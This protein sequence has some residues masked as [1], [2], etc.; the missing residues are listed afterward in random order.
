LKTPEYNRCFMK[1]EKDTEQLHLAFGFPG[2]STGNDEAYALTALNTLLGGGMSSR[3]FQNIREKHGLVYSIYSYNTSYNDTGLFSIYAAL[4][5]KHAK[6]AAELIIGEIKN[7]YADRVT[8]QVLEKTKEQIKSNYLLGLESS[9]NRMS[10]IGRGLLL[11]NR[12]LTFDQVIE[13][14]DAVDIGRLYALADDL[15]RLENMSVSAVGKVENIDL[16][17]LINS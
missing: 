10:S 5:P 15:L 1:K 3:L 8:E 9:S 16:K 14:I 17:K 6:K 11:L 12:T 13:K 4:N 7:L 2:L